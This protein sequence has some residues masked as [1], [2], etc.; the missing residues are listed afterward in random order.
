MN[1][2]ARSALEIVQSRYD[3]YL[4]QLGEFITIPSISINPDYGDETKRAGEWMAERLKAL[5]PSRL[6]VFPTP[7]YP[8]VFADLPAD[9]PNLPTVMIYGHYDVM[10]VEPLDEWDT[11]PF[12]MERKGDYVFGRGTSDMKGQI[13]ACLAAVEALQSA[14]QLPLHLKFLMEGEEESSPN[15]LDQV[16]AENRELFACDVCL[17]PDAG[18]AGPDTPTI[19]YGL[20]GH[21]VGIL[22]LQGPA[23]D[24]HSGMYGGV[25]ANPLHV[26]SGLIARFH[27][28]HGRI[29]IPGFYEDVVEISEEERARLAELPHS[30]EAYIQTTGVPK[31][32]GEEGYSA[33][34]RVT[35]RPSLNVVYIKGGSMKSAVPSKAEAGIG[36]RVV[37]HQKPE[38]IFNSL[39][40]FFEV[41]IPDTVTWEFERRGKCSAVL[42]DVDSPWVEAMQSAL[43]STWGK[44]PILDRIGGSLPVASDLRN[45]LGVESIL[46]GFS[47]PGDN[48]HGPNEHLHL[49]TWKKGIQA[50]IDFL[51]RSYAH[52]K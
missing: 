7:R 12:S 42:M 37:P 5:H 25:V 41:S 50:L 20:R 28:D 22:R 26:L 2:L 52:V 3:D 35:V 44:P 45:E 49:P 33:F 51:S 43:E 23:S 39:E 46:T 40:R 47:L 11:G 36:V 38:T 17:N 31:L 21:V 8:V 32:W 13:M 15:H 19:V 18:M 10:D 14:G 1:D 48:I 24:L 16:L 27:D 30:D 6:E 4:D 29:A 9:D 34:E